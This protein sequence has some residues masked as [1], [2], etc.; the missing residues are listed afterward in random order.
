MMTWRD[1][2]QQAG[3]VNIKRFRNLQPIKVADATAAIVAAGESGNMPALRR[4]VAV[5]AISVQF[6]E[7]IIAERQRSTWRDDTAPAPGYF[8]REV[9]RGHVDPTQTIGINPRSAVSI[10]QSQ[11]DRALNISIKRQ[12]EQLQLARNTLRLAER[13]ARNETALTLA[14]HSYDRAVARIRADFDAQESAIE[15]E[16]REFRFA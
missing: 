11:R 7:T 2:R 6:A 14:R 12:N 15:R 16:Y 4:A 1:Y 13:L 5:H 10:L 8:P 9:K 3:T